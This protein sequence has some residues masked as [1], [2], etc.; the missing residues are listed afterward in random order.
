MI[1]KKNLLFLSL[2]TLAITGR[3]QSYQFI[4]KGSVGTSGAQA[5]IHL[6]YYRDNTPVVDSAT[7]ING[8]FMLT[9]HVPGPTFAQ[10]MLDHTGKGLDSPGGGDDRRSIYLDSGTVIVTARD[11]IRRA[12][13]SGFPVNE[14]FERYTA[15]IT[16]DKH[17]VNDAAAERKVRQL[18]YIHENPD[19]YF[20]LQALKEITGL[21]VDPAIVKPLYEHLSNRIRNSPEG[22]EYKIMITSAEQTKIGSIAP[23]FTQDDANGKA[24]KLSSYRGKYVLLDFWASWCGPCRKI[25]PGLVKAWHK[26]KNHDFIVLGISLDVRNNRGAWLNAIRADHLDWTQVSDLNGWN[27]KVVKKYAIKSIPQNF[28]LDPSGK[29]IARNLNGNMLEQKLAQLLNQPIRKTTQQKIQ[30]LNS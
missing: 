15:F 6:I 1:I 21:S 13:I 2:I 18:K 30:K 17:S 11:S 27:N 5:K 8:G 24:I 12:Q 28:L 9:G 20:S 3:C 10:L 29:I 16:P 22:L 23:D 7:L 26:F 4:L 14:Q 25:N 19:S